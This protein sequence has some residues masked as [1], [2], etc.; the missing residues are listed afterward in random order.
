MNLERRLQQAEGIIVRL[1][2]EAYLRRLREDPTLG[3]DYL[4]HV[5]LAQAGILEHPGE[6][7]R[8]DRLDREQWIMEKAAEEQPLWQAFGESLDELPEEELRALQ[9]L[10]FLDYFRRPGILRD[11][12]LPN[13]EAAFCEW[14]REQSGRPDLMV[15]N[16]AQLVEE[17][18]AEVAGALYERTAERAGVT[19]EEL[20]RVFQPPAEECSQS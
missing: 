5:T 12:G 19:V 16:A 11:F 18:W 14:L 15:E 9:L 4:I 7:Q 6:E 20:I 2:K 10:G 8:T 13:A 17:R 3:A 1:E